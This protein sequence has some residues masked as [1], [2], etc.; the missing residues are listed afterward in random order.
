DVITIETKAGIKILKMDIKDG[1]AVGATVD[2]GEPQIIPELVPIKADVKNF[3]NKPI[4]YLDM[5]RKFTAVSMGNPH[6]ITY[7]DDVNAIDIEKEGPALEHH[8]MFPERTNIE[9]IQ[10]VS[11]R[12]LIMRVWERGSGETLACGTG[13]CAVAVSGVLNGINER[14]V[15]IHLRGGDLKISYDDKTNHVFMT[16]N[17]VEVFRG[18][19]EV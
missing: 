16:G 14:E 12:E 9:F 13:A 4:A 15:L 18:E 7:V 17:A 3:I 2:M 19:V 6:I 11:P 5:E 8:D 10:V 1:K